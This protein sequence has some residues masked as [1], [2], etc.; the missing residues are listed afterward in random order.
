MTRHPSAEWVVQ[1]LREAFSE[2]AS[3]RYVI[4]DRDAK[5]DANVISFLQGAGL[6]L[7]KTNVQSPWQNGIAER[8]VGSCRRELL[9]HVIPLHEQHLRR[10]VR[11]YGAYYQQDSISRRSGQRHTQSAAAS[12]KETLTEGDGDFKRPLGRSPSSLLMARSG[13]ADSLG[14]L[15]AF[16]LRLSA[17][18]HVRP[19]S[20]CCKSTATGLTPASRLCIGNL[21][22]STQ[23][24]LGPSLTPCHTADLV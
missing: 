14:R 19:T 2:A 3:Y 16:C 5:F 7:K 12:R 18:M 20:L 17:T 24:A 11:D 1:Q 15:L 6:T 4:L 9:D 23:A 22:V 10:L 13:V 21:L 8:W